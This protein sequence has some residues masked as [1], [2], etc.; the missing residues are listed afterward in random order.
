M[1][2]MDT[3]TKKHRSWNMSRIRSTDTLAERTVRAYLRKRKLR[4]RSNQRSLPGKP[5]VVFPELSAILFI[6][7]CFWHSHRGCER[8]TMPKTHRAYWGPKLMAN[9]KRDQR[10]YKQLRNLGFRVHVI[11]ECQCKSQSKLDNLYRRITSIK[12]K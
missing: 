9:R 7:G 11:W 5:D 4:F 12:T 3:I 10:H 1:N 6:H 8:A 2:I